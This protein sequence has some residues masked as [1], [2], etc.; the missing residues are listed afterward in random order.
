M[1]HIAYNQQDPDDLIRLLD[2]VQSISILGMPLNFN[3][4]TILIL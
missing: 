1:T 2:L 3:D 4:F